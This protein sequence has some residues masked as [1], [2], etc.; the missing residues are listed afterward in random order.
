MRKRREI[1]RQGEKSFLLSAGLE[2]ARLRISPKPQKRDEQKQKEQ[3]NPLVR[4]TTQLTQ[5]SLPFF[6]RLPSLSAFARSR[7]Q[8]GAAQKVPPPGDCKVP[9]CQGTERDGAS[10]ERDAAAALQHQ[11]STPLQGQDVHLAHLLRPLRLTL[12]GHHAA[13]HAVPM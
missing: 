5:T 10:Q 7:L 2:K 11:H 6:S 3:G 9:R 4:E 1:E 12:V 13:G 8:D